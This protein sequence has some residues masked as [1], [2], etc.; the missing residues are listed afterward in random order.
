MSALTAVVVVAFSLVYAFLELLGLP[1]L[2]AA[3]FS[4]IIWATFVPQMVRLVAT[5]K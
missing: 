4:N 3:W 2:S 5:G 1:R